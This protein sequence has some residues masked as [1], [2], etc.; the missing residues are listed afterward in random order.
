MPAFVAGPQA[1]RHDH[2][3]V[4]DQ[5]RRNGA[6]NEA[7][8]KKVIGVAD[9]DDLAVALLMSVGYPAERR[10]HPAG[11]PRR[12]TSSTFTTPT[13]SRRLRPGLLEQLE[14]IPR[15]RGLAEVGKMRSTL[16]RCASTSPSVIASVAR[17]T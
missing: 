5:A 1:W 9:R 15:G 8:V 7:K 2:S 14:E 11:T 12:A 13:R 16:L 4:Y 10:S 6:W 17:T 3:D